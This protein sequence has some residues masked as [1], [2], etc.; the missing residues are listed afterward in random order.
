VLTAHPF[1]SGRPSR[2]AALGQLMAEAAGAGDVW[3]APL[4]EVA[5]HVR[6]QRL[7]PRVLTPPVIGP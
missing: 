2:A 4:A 1:L 3:V 5:A 6:G 7:R